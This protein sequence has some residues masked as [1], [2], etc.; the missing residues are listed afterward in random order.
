MPKCT[1][2]GDY[3]KTDW[4]KTC[5]KLISVQQQHQNGLHLQLNTVAVT[6]QSFVIDD[7]QYKHYS[8]GKPKWGRFETSRKTFDWRE[9]HQL[10]VYCVEQLLLVQKDSGLEKP[11]DGYVVVNGLGYKKGWWAG[12]GNGRTNVVKIQMGSNKSGFSGHGY[13]LDLTNYESRP[14]NSFVVEIDYEAWSNVV[15]SGNNDCI[16]FKNTTNT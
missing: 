9:I 6:L 4:C 5:K 11:S 8:N 13:P 2:C 7:H 3:S 12:T 15:L 10:I 1:D 14:R 16:R